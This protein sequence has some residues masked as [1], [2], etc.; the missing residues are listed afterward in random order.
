MY[1]V[2]LKTVVNVDVVG[3]TAHTHLRL[4]RIG[5]KPPLGWFSRGLAVDLLRRFQ[6]RCRDLL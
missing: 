5:R 3:R 6:E 4:A 2:R 1:E